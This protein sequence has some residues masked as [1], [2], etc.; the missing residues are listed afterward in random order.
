MLMLE[1]GD[2]R[3][4]AMLEFF[5]DVFKI[6]N[7]ETAE[8]HRRFLATQKEPHFQNKNTARTQHLHNITGTK[9]TTPVF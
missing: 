9:L 4:A 1:E 8:L 6:Q 3:T 2:I 7:L 5:A